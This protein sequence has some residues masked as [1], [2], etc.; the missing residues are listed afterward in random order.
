[1]NDVILFLINYPDADNENINGSPAKTLLSVANEET[2]SDNRGDHN[3]AD[4][5]P[6]SSGVYKTFYLY[7]I[8]MQKNSQLFANI[9][10][11]IIG[12]TV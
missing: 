12:L 11:F 7:L 8:T 2:Q 6:L 4:E 1:M 5:T 3:T 10:I 9:L